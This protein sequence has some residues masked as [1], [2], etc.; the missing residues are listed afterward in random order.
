MEKPEPK[1]RGPK[2]KYEH[3]R[4]NQDGAPSITV[5]FE[6]EIYEWVR[7]RPEGTRPYLERIILADKNAGQLAGLDPQVGP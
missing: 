2:P 7:S 3:L 6:P 1:K 5:R 4:P